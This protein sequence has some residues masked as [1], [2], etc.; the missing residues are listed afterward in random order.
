[1]IDTI[2][3]LDEV[4]RACVQNKPIPDHLRQWIAGS[5]TRFLDHDCS[6]LDDAF[7]LRQ[8]HGGIPWWREKAIRTRDRA[9]RELARTHLASDT[10][11][12]QARKIHA[13][14]LR[15]AGT[16]WNRDRNCDSMPAHYAGTPK[17]YLWIAFK[18]GAKTPVS[19]RHLRNL[20]AGISAVI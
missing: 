18:S 10:T 14:M 7:G 16:A 5:I 6:D 1:M 15:Y 17:E 8:E 3:A 13:L 2:Q 12:V 11:S 19:D 4:C 9:L 20:L